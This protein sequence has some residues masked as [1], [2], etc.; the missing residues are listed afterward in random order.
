MLPGHQPRMTLDWD[1]LLFKITGGLW[2]I[3]IIIQFLKIT[4]SEGVFSKQGSLFA[5][6]S[7]WYVVSYYI[8]L[9]Y[10]WKK[11]TLMET[12]LNGFFKIPKGKF[13]LRLD[14]L[15]I[16]IIQIKVWLKKPCIIGQRQ[17]TNPEDQLQN[18]EFFWPRRAGNQAFTECDQVHSSHK[19]GN[20]VGSMHTEWPTKRRSWNPL[21]KYSEGTG[22]AYCG[23]KKGQED[24]SLFYNFLR[25]G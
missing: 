21:R 6:G 14:N 22:V 11:N 2:H 20:M 10:Y 7:V 9:T 3:K 18:R 25:E 15:P 8:R 16:R 17:S 24:F 23:E 13:K 5:K 4:C 1:K 12:P 19:K